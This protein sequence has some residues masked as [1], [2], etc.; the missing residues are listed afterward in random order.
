MTF[1]SLQI[2]TPMLELKALETHQSLLPL[3][4]D[5]RDTEEGT[6]PGLCKGLPI[7]QNDGLRKPLFL[8]QI[9]IGF[10]SRFGHGEFLSHGEDEKL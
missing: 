6:L 8:T 4:P 9:D 2:P 7:G 10:I 3:H 1:L 5:T